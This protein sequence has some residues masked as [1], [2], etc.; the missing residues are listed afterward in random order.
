MERKEHGSVTK[1]P[2]NLNEGWDMRE[3]IPIRHK[4][5]RQHSLTAKIHQK[6]WGKKANKATQI[7]R[8]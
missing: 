6:Q 8:S 3:G 5:E 4:K 7:D 2:L 1:K